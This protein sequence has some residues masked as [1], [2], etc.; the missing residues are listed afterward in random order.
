MTASNVVDIG[1]ALDAPQDV[2]ELSRPNPRDRDE[3]PPERPMLPRDCPVKPLGVMAQTHF[4]L[5]SLGQLI[6]L[7]P[8]E[9]GK[10]HI[11]ALFGVHSAMLREIW[12]RFSPKVDPETGEA[13]VTGWKADDAAEHLKRAAA[14]EGIFDPQGRVRGR[15]AHRG[16][17]GEL[18]LHCGDMVLIGGKRITGGPGET[19]WHHP[20][21]IGPFVYPTAP[22]MPRPHPEA[23][24]DEAAV[25]LLKLLQQWR[26]ARPD[27]D[28]YLMLGWI[29]AALIAG[30]LDWRPH[31]WITGGSGTGK[32]TLHRLLKMLFGTGALATADATPAA[33]RQLLQQQ[34]LPVFFDELEAEEDGRRS[35]AVIE[36]ARLA[37]SGALTFRGGTDHKASEFTVRSSFLFSSILVPPMPQQDRNRLAMLELEKFE[38]GAQPPALERMGLPDLGRRLR[39]RLLDQWWRWDATLHAYQAALSSYGHNGRSGDQF[40]TLLAAADL[41]LYDF[42]PEPDVVEE[43]ASKL[44]ADTLAEKVYERTDSDEC[45][46]WLASTELKGRGGDERE[47]VA[48]A[49]RL[50]LQLDTLEMA[51]RRRERLRSFG[52]AIGN[53]TEAG[54]FRDYAG[55]AA[56]VAIANSHRGLDELFRDSRWVGGV[57]SQSFARAREARKR[58]KVKFDG[59]AIWATVVPIEL[60]IGSEEAP[61]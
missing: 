57:W 37:S 6:A 46:D 35:K 33:I 29:A 11:E 26:W 36:L 19:R 1:A 48:K 55:G 40:G 38:T 51:A 42:Q 54:G 59:R 24:D 13:K 44:R 52:I 14:W 28:A 60:F 34:T 25:I 21:V 8:R 27:I 12:P 47:T 18:V 50:G 7:G 9:H 31:A 15:G 32:S 2:P 30:A 61:E 4:Y 5:D 10:Q 23:V 45:A 56:F 43:W 20:G 16:E 3:G 41:L 53:V 58:V 49:M 39:R 17:A 22:G